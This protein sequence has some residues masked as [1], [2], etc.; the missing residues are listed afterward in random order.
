MIHQAEL[1]GIRR[2]EMERHLPPVSGSVNPALLE[3]IGR[4]YFFE[5]NGLHQRGP[6]GILGVLHAVRA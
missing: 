2:I 6:M 1:E 4:H 3:Y 5:T